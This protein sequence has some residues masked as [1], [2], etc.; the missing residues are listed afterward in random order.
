MGFQWGL[1]RIQKAYGGLEVDLGA[2]QEL[3]ALFNDP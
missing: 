2:T 1:R 3:P